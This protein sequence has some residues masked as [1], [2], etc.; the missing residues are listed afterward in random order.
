MYATLRDKAR[1]D[2]HS[3]GRFPIIF[4]T[5]IWSRD[6]GESFISCTAHHITSEFTREERILQVHPF[7]GSHTADPIAEMISKLLEV[8]NI[9]KAQVHAI[10][11][12]NAANMV[13]GIRQC[14]ML[15]VSCV[16]HTI[17]LVVKDSIFIQKGITDILGRLL[18]ISSIQ[19]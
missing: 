7:L 11:R 14:G 1:Q 17:Q 8:W 4:T 6:G 9:D 13:A 19:V 10:V 16:I 18:A 3:V 2:L 12:D 15:T 5:D